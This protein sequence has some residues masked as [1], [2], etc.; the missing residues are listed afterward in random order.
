MHGFAAGK[1]MAV[2]SH[3]AAARLFAPAL[4]HRLVDAGYIR[5]IP[6]AVHAALA[7]IG[8]HQTARTWPALANSHDEQTDATPGEAG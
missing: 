8:S 2:K 6:N 5:G 4:E 3:V 1:M 7:T